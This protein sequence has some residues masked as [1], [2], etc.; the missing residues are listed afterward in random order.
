VEDH[1]AQNAGVVD[2]V[3]PAEMI[4]RVFTILSRDASANDSGAGTAPR[5]DLLD[6]GR[7]ALEPAPSA[8]TP[9]SLT[10]TWRL[11]GAEQRDPRADA[12]LRR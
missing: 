5:F 7:A 4:G 12:G 3:E 8:A 10:T 6:P 9:G 11:P 2:D 1:V